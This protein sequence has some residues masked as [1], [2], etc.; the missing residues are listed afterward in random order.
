MSASSAATSRWWSW[1]WTATF[2]VMFG[3]FI[4][5]MLWMSGFQ[6]PAVLVGIVAALLGMYVLSFG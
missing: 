2:A 5:A 1:Q 6:I 4:G 3:Y